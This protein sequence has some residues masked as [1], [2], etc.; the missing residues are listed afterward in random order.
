MNPLKQAEVTRVE[1]AL[2]RVR[3][4]EQKR[5]VALLMVL[6]TLSILAVMLTEFQD[7]TSAEL[8]SAMAARDQI[9]AEYAAKSGV[10]LTR[11]I[12]ASEPTVRGPLAILTKNAQIPIWEYTDVLLGPFNDAAGASLFSGFTGLDLTETRNLGLDGASFEIVVVDEDSKINLNLGARADAFSRMRLTE[13]LLA[14]MIGPQYDELFDRRDETGNINDRQTICGALVDWVDPDQNRDPCDPR[15]ETNVNAGP[16]DSYYQ[17]LPRPYKRRNAGFD[18]LEEVR[19]VR[20][21]SDEFWRTFFQPDPDDPKSRTVTVW[22][23]SKV[24]VS[25]TSA[26]GLMT[27]LCQQAKPEQPLCVDPEM[28]F[29]FLALMGMMEPLLAGLPKFPRPKDFLSAIDGK[30]LIGE[31]LASQDI[32]LPQQLSKEQLLKSITSESHV[33]SIYS[34]GSV[35]AGKRVTRRRIHAVVDMRGAPPPWEKPQV[36]VNQEEPDA[37]PVAI[38]PGG[39]IIYYR[40]D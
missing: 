34:T 7:A 16:E 29:K 3:Q 2:A 31:M 17:G 11:L 26:R 18:S 37:L 38:R 36:V 4:G 9:R 8:G 32:E 24:N 10:N 27:L 28:Q 25:T 33:F 20:G 12:L 30:G 23:G 13:Q 35:G 14:M 19:L 40:V 22:G 15:A 1:Q 21:I 39:Q 6:S 5:G